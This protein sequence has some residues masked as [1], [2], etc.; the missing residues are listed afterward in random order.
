MEIKVQV[1]E[2]ISIEQLENGLSQVG[3]E[4]NLEITLH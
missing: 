1:P 3:E 4:L 2:R